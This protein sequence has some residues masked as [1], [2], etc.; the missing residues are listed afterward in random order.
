MKTEKSKVLI[1]GGGRCPLPGRPP[2]F[3][4][5]PSAQVGQRETSS[6]GE[7]GKTDLGAANQA[8]VGTRWDAGV[9]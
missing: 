8:L 4:V 9:Q 3:Q 2:V 7:S 5:L 6:S 1:I